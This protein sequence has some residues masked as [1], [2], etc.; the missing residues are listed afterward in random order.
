MVNNPKLQGRKHEECHMTRDFLRIHAPRRRLGSS[1]CLICH[2]S[3]SHART[4][5]LRSQ[6][7]RCIAPFLAWPGMFLRTVPTIQAPRTIAE[8]G[9]WVS[10]R[11]PDGMMGVM[12]SMG[13]F[14]TVKN[15]ADLIFLSWFLQIY[16]PGEPCS[17]L[18]ASFPEPRR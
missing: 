9:G 13:R 4:Q 17:L 6:P 14:Y 5:P 8:V 3:L 16:V 2:C 7:A 11:L 15:M 1:R 10:S 12:G 18:P